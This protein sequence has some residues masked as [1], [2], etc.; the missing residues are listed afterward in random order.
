VSRARHEPAQFA[1]RNFSDKDHFGPERPLA[2]AGVRRDANPGPAEGVG[3]LFED[4]NRS[5]RP[6]SRRRPDT[7]LSAPEPRLADAL[8]RRHCR[9]GALQQPGGLPIFDLVGTYDAAFGIRESQSP[10][11]AGDYFFFAGAFFLAVVFLTVFFTAGF[12][13]GFAFFTILHS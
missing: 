11:A 2:A 10:R 7:G 12:A 6:G 5:T 8:C 13:F 1:R 3:D 4:R 9:R